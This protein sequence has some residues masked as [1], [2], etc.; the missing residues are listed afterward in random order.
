M[1]A[2]DAAPGCWVASTSSLDL[3]FRDFPDGSVCFDTATG[4]TRLLSPLT[5]F[6]LEALAAAAPAALARDRL[7]EQVLAVDESDADALTAAGL[8]DAALAELAQAGLVHAG[9]SA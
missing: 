6:L 7:I 1:P 4:E 5:R 8:V 9:G 3:L 2:G